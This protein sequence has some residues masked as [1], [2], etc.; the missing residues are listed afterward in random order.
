MN[1][2]TVSVINGCGNT[3]TFHGDGGETTEDM[4][5]DEYSLQP[6]FFMVV[7]N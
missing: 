1:T 6:M 3:D 7:S 2:V 4:C 5:K